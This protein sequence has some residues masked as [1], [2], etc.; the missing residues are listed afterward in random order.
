LLSQDNSELA[1]SHP[2]YHE[3]AHFRIGRIHLPVA[4]KCNI[5]CNFCDKK[6]SACDHTSRPGLAY[7]LMK[8][9]DVI[10]AVEKSISD[11]PNLEVV[12]IAGPGEPLYNSETFESL[13]LISRRFPNLKLC[14]CTNGLLLPEK[15]KILRELNVTSLTVTINAIDP[16]LASKISSYSIINGKK[17]KGVE[18]ARQLVNRQLE[19]LHIA[20]ELGFLIKVNT[21][22]IPEIN[23]D[24]VKKIAYEV[25]MRGAHI[26]N[27]MPLIPMG[28]F[29]NQRAPTCDELIQTREIAEGIIPIFRACKQCRADACGIP[30]KEHNFRNS[31]TIA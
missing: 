28:N 10:E 17:I 26:L 4:R 1:H 6:G 16:S 25:E 22:L 23:M 24:H 14:I 29:A 9:D 12:G 3:K 31:K 8:P 2:C 15:T 5:G 13:K 18:G 7:Q 19:G 11:H 30:G 20:S 21:V 27:I